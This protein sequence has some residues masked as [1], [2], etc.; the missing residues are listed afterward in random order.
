MR[1][2]LHSALRGNRIDHYGSACCCLQLMQLILNE[3]VIFPDVCACDTDV[4]TPAAA[5]Q[6]H[7]CGSVSRRVGTTACI[8]KVESHHFRGARHRLCFMIILILPGWSGRAGCCGG[9]RI[10]LL[11]AMFNSQLAVCFVCSPRG[12][13]APGEQVT[14]LQAVM[15]E[16]QKRKEAL[17]GMAAPAGLTMRA[18]QAGRL[19]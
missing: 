5:T 7:V 17:P 1:W 9:T 2:A 8:S 6:Q 14:L 13:N 11:A 4:K 10:L 12:R 18:A 15:T 19:P 3:S 16:Q